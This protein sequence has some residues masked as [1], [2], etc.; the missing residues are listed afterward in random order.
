MLN[1]KAILLVAHYDSV[2]QSFGASDDGAGVVAL[3]ETLRALTS[4]RSVKKDVIALFT[5]GEELDRL[6]AKA[7]LQHHQWMREVELVL[8]FEARGTQ[9]PAFMFE[10]SDHNGILIREFARAVRAP[11]TNSIAQIVYGYL[12]NDTDLGAFKSAGYPGLNFAFVDA[13]RNYHTNNDSIKTVD[14]RSIQHE[15]ASALSLTRHF[16]NL[17]LG[18][19]KAADVVYFDILG[20]TVIFYSKD[21]AW[22]LTVCNI[23]LFIGIL[24]YRLRKKRLLI[25]ETALGVLVS[26]I[27]IVAVTVVVML[28]QEALS[29]KY[30]PMDLIRNDRLYFIFFAALALATGSSVYLY[31][32]RRASLDN[33]NCGLLLAYLI[34]LNIITMYLPGAS[35]ILAWPLLFNLLGLGLNT[36]LE[37]KDARDS[38]LLA[39]RCVIAVPVVALLGW[40]MLGLFQGISLYSPIALM[41]ILSLF[42]GFFL[43]S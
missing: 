7:F 10:T 12:P 37:G 43:P 11:F 36:Y 5:D 39:C 22:A 25:G 14:E 24:I 30:R 40:T 33:L 23:L 8:N 6:G 16:G 2:P 28:A 29:L 20:M 17:K 38:V 4:D 41:L 31:F 13:V 26:V 21:W 32:S 1:E 34:I 15:G 35:Y 42:A 19:L 3:L 27:A 18:S 9:G